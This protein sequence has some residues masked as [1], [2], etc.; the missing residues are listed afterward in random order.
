MALALSERIILFFSIT[1]LTEAIPAELRRI[2]PPWRGSRRLRECEARGTAVG[3][4]ACALYHEAKARHV[5][6]TTLAKQLDQSGVAL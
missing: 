2:A 1:K 4:R 3:A 5:P 6:M